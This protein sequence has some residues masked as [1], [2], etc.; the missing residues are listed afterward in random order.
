MLDEIHISPPNLEPFA[1]YFLVQS[2]GSAL[3]LMSP[4]AWGVR[5]IGRLRSFFLFFGLL[6]KRGAAPFHQWF[7]SVCSN[8]S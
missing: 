7:P 8:V 3:F 6:I 5:V 4:L 1:K 2:V